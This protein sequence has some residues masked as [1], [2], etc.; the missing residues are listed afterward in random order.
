MNSVNLDFVIV[1]VIFVGDG[2]G[3]I[4]SGYIHSLHPEAVILGNHMGGENR[5]GNY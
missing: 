2:G 3:F 4:L 1:I 5:V